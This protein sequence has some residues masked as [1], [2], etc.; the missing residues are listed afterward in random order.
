MVRRSW[1]MLDAR[2]RF[3]ELV[4]AAR[5]APQTVT[6]RGKPAVVV[7]D[8]TEYERL[9]RLERAPSF[10]DVLLTMP[11]DGGEFPNGRVRMRDF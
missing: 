8:V 6:K 9:C 4:G 10:A 7:M 5:R 11:Q 2:N 3:D 1:S